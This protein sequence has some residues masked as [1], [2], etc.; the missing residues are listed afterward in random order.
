MLNITL[1]DKM[2]LNLPIIE[3][4]ASAHNIL[5]AGAGGG[6]DILQGLPLYFTLRD[7]GY[8]VYLAN[9]TFSPF[10]LIGHYSKIET[11]IP[12]RLLGTS[13][14]VSRS[15]PYFPE[16]YLAHWFKE[17]YGE[18]ITIWMFSKTG[19]AGLRECYQTLI[20]CLHIDAIV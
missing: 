5:I 7:A 2:R 18:E 17:V 14:T 1:E 3:H 4:L 8:T 13:G 19:A 9:Y 15:L 11:L 20:D 6:F 16:G 12:D 10:E